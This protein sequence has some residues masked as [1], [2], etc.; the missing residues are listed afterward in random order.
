[1]IRIR[2]TV[3]DGFFMNYELYLPE[4]A[5]QALP[6][7]VYLH[8]AGE[9][10]TV[11]D[12]LTRH[13]IPKLIAEGREIPALVLCPQCPADCVWDN[14]PF[15]LKK[16]IDGV[17]DEYRVD[18]ARVTLTGGSMGGYGTWAI[19]MTFPSF[20]AALAPIAGGGMSWRTPNLVGTPV[21][22][23]HGEDDTAVPL[24]YAELMVDAL[25]KNGGDVSLT[26]LHGFGHND[27][28]NAAYRDGDVIEWLLSKRRTDFSPVSETMSK[29]F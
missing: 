7:I 12:H 21:R 11:L 4:D 29:Y 15:E 20:F 2:K 3:E 16:I 14:I 24:V 27:G 10:G 8:G 26:V 28:I 6:M 1:M 18:R 25:A 19:G 13:G 22:A 17:I 5:P 9:R 23:Y